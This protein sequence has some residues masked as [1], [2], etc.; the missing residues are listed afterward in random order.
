MGAPPVP[1]ALKKRLRET[2]KG[3][4]ILAGGYDAATAEAALQAQEADLIAFGRPFLANPDL[5]QRMKTGA[6]MNAPDMASFYTAD[7]KG[8]T[9]YPALP[10]K[11]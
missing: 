9:D 6:A 10:A 4:F 5:V 7:A 3:P 8:Y 11:S 1:A 2:F